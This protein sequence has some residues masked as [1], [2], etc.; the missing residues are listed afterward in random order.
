[1]VY[2]LILNPG[3]YWFQLL[4]LGELGGQKEKKKGVN[5]TKNEKMKKKSPNFQ[6]HKIYRKT[7]GWFAVVSFDT[8]GSWILLHLL[9]WN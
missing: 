2:Y 5:L 8:P 9:F 4:F 3:E 1:M 7:P 6:N